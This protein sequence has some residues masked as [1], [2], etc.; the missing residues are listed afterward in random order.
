MGGQGCSRAFPSVD[1][2]RRLPCTRAY[3]NALSSH[4]PKSF[5]KTL[6]APLPDRDT[7]KHGHSHSSWSSVQ[8]FL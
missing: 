4:F 2:H 1:F 7:A 5:F 8:H 3:F 6:G